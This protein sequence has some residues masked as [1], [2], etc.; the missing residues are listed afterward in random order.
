MQVCTPP[1]SRMQLTPKHFTPT[2][3]VHGIGNGKNRH[4]I[5]PASLRVIPCR[6]KAA[7]L[8]PAL[9]WGRKAPDPIS[10]HIAHQTRHNLGSYDLGL[11]SVCHQLGHEAVGIE[12]DHI[13]NIFSDPER[14]NRQCET[15]GQ[16]NQDAAFAAAIQ[17][18][19]DQAGDGCGTRE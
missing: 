17:L 13:I 4:G 1:K 7:G 18:G 16:R 11:V 15:I 6:E 14:M 10:W 19:H 5:T 9:R 3:F 12:R 8:R 2:D